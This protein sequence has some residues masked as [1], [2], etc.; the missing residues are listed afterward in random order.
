[1]INL[2]TLLGRLVEKPVLEETE[3]GKKTTTIVLAVSR[4]FKNDIGEYETDFIP[5]NLVGQV[6]S[7]TVEYCEKGDVIGIRGRL[8]RLKGNDLQVVAEK[9]SFLSSRPKD[10]DEE[11]DSQVIVD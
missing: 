6:A 10:Y 9:I 2:V 1:M 3:N 7:S 11:N 4:N 5:V 8:A